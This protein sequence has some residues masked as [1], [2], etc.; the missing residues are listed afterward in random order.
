MLLAQLPLWWKLPHHRA[1]SGTGLPLPAFYAERVSGGPAFCPEFGPVDSGV[2]ICAL[3][4]YTIWVCFVFL[5]VFVCPSVRLSVFLLFWWCTSC[6]PF[7]FKRGRGRTF[8]FAHV[9]VR[10]PV[11][12]PRLSDNRVTTA[13]VPS[14]RGWVVS[15]GS[16]MQEGRHHRGSSTSGRRV[17]SAPPGANR[18]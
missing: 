11:D 4:I 16:H 1:S 6:G 18:V 17:F 3:T 13:C 10:A 15:V 5:A 12:R 14:P 9:L 8:I 2:C 7:I